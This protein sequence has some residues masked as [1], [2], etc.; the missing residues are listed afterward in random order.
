MLMSIARPLA[1]EFGAGPLLRK[2][3]MM[4]RAPSAEKDIKGRRTMPN[5]L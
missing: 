3:T 1:K 2:K 4:A 5:H